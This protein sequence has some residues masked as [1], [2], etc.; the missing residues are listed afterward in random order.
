MV[1]EV[2]TAQC[3]VIFDTD[4]LHRESI[5]TGDFPPGTSTTAGSKEL[6]MDSVDMDEPEYD[7]LKA[8]W[9]W[10]LLEIIP[11]PYSWQDDQGVWHRKWSFH[12]GAGRL[13]PTA[14]PN[15]HITVKERMADA[16]LKWK[17]KAQYT[18]GTEVFVE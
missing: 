6:A 5:P 13:I 10:W 2:M 12:L 17:P 9:L 18:P 11:L 1:R 16:T 7:Q 3:G 14:C 15:F 4:A 8:N